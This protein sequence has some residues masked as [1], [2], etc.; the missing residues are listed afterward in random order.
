MG[1]LEKVKKLENL[2]NQAF[3]ED[4]KI[5]V[6]F[7]DYET[8]KFIYENEEFDSEEEFKKIKGITKN[9]NTVLISIVPA[10]EG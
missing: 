3:Q 4:T 5:Y 6:L 1:N 9:A 7:K 10:G 8:K 2:I